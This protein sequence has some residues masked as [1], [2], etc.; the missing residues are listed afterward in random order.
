MNP[1]VGMP[2]NRAISGIMR[3]SPQV[4]MAPSVSADHNTDKHLV[5]SIPSLRYPTGRDGLAMNVVLPSK[6]GHLI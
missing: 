4:Q 3:L 6:T 1:L 5:S 2:P